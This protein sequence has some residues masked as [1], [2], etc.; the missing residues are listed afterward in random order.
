MQELALTQ[1][2]LDKNV[3]STSSSSFPTEVPVHVS[4][5]FIM[6]AFVFFM[7]N[8]STSA[9][10]LVDIFHLISTQPAANNRLSSTNPM[11]PLS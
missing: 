8:H 6:A 7:H 2:I 1:D 9:N 11:N 10:D 3:L 4:D 5:Q